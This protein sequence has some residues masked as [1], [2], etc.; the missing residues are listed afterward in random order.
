MRDLFAR[1]GFSGFCCCSQVCDLAVTV[2]VFCCGY[3]ACDLAVTQTVVFRTDCVWVG[4]RVWWF[5]L[6][7]YWFVGLVGFGLWIWLFWLLS[8]GFLCSG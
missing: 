2:G 7:G 8:L 6:C 5:V 1:G 3:V 4:R